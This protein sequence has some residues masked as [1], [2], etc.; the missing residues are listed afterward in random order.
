MDYE[1][2]LESIG[3]VVKVSDGTERPPER[4][5]RKLEKWEHSNF[6]G[7]LAEVEPCKYSPSGYRAKILLSESSVMIAYSSVDLSSVSL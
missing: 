5:N 4:F 3:T 1:K 7:K 2:A 6:S